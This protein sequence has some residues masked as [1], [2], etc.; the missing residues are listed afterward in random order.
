MSSPL[1]TAA[2]TKGSLFAGKYLTVALDNESYGV[3][4]LKVREIIRMQKITPVPQM[5]EFVRGFAGSSDIMRGRSPLANINFVTAHDGF[6]L[7]DLVSYDQKHNWANGE[8]NA[9]GTNENYSWNCGAEGPTDDAAIFALRA[10]QKRN[11]I[12]TILL[13]LGIPMLNAGDELG[14]SQS[15]NNNAYCQDN[16]F[17][18]IGW[19]SDPE[20]EAFLDFVRRVIALRA[21]HPVFTEPLEPE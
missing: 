4:V 10:R 17:G 5:P 21:E 6:T 2:S 11:L 16:E 15:G 20:G 18:W 3:A 12:G 7:Q 13:S 14:H 8:G 9:D 1:A 19:Q